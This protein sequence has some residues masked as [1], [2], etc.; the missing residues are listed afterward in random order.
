MPTLMVIQMK[1]NRPKTVKTSKET[2]QSAR[3]IYET[4]D[5]FSKKY[6]GLEHNT[7]IAPELKS[8]TKPI[9]KN[10][11]SHAVCRWVEE[12]PDTW[13]EDWDRLLE[14]IEKGNEFMKRGYKNLKAPNLAWLFSSRGGDMGLVRVIDGSY[15]H[16][17]HS[18]YS[19]G[20][21]T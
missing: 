1:F 11:L 20:D 4:F 7:R 12:N 8:D 5:S 6:L 2:R 3:W 13:K 9:V 10:S 18:T 21:M 17:N 14:E 15:S 19:D 16:W